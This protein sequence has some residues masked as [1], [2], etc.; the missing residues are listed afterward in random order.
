VTRSRAYKK[1]DQFV[2]QK[3]VAVVRR[4]MVYGRFDS[5]ETA[6]LMGRLYR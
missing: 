3:N 2:E 5:V 6:R 1:N 4:L